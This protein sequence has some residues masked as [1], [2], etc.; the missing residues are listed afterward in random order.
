MRPKEVIRF[1]SGKLHLEGILTRS[2][3]TARVAVISHPH[4]LYGGDMDN[5]VVSLLGQAFGRLGWS[6]LIFNFRGV[7]RSEGVFDQG[8]GEQQDVL[9]AL[10]FLKN[11]GMQDIVLAGYSFGAWVNAQAAGMEPD[12]IASLLV[13]PPLA[14]LDFSFVKDDSKTKLIICG[15]RDEFCPSAD[16]N[17][18]I[19]E[20]P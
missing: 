9:S 12:L 15:D 20:W 17:K 6:T 14:M 13:S 8:R 3:K 10:A 18:L 5:Y 1:P 19:Q 7:G 11:L 16:L 2:Q 4:P